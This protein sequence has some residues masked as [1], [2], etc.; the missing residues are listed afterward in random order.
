LL[1]ERHSG[2]DR[3][4]V[5]VDVRGPLLAAEAEQVEPLGGDGPAN[6][7]A[8]PVH[9]CLEREVLV[10]REVVDHALAVVLGRATST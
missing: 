3:R 8:H 1:V 9:D 2:R 7:T 5:P 10:E 6:S 4:E